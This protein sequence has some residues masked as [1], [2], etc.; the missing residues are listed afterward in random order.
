MLHR[1]YEVRED[2]ASFMAMKGKAVPELANEKWIHDMAFM[3][4]IT[5]HL[6]ALNVKLQGCK[7]LITDMRDAVK[8]FRT[9]LRLW[10][11]QMQQGN[12]VHFPTC[13]SVAD[14]LNTAFPNERCAEKL[15]TL[16]AEFER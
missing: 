13:Q 15:K 10:E 5:H 16:K 9:K 3:C 7:Q 14:N 11:N 1:F 4:D 12:H 8:V 2:I 6:N